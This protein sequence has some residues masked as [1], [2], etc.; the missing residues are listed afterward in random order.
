MNLFLVSYC[1][2]FPTDGSMHRD[3]SFFDVAWSLLVNFFYQSLLY[4]F[5]FIENR[6]WTNNVKHKV[7]IYCFLCGKIGE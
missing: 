2:Q 3:S 7:I 6:N 5:L 4:F 1:V